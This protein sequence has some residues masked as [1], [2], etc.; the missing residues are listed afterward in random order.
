MIIKK[1]YSVQNYA[2]F[3]VT[4]VVTPKNKTRIKHSVKKIHLD[5]KHFG[6]IGA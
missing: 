6:I 3:W 4:S 2:I 1:A 5:E